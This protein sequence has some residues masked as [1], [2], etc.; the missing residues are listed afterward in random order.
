MTCTAVTTERNGD[1]TAF[2]RGED[3]TIAVSSGIVVAWKRGC[4]QKTISSVIAKN[5]AETAKVGDT[6]EYLLSVAKNL[7][8]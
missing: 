3:M 8:A 6:N 2:F 4:T 1:K 5:I 7:I